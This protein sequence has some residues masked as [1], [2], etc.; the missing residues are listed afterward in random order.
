MRYENERPPVAVILAAGV[1]SRT[2]DIPAA[3]AKFGS[4]VVTVSRGQQ[5]AMDEAAA[6]PAPQTCDI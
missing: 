5:R 4:P 1:G 6:K 3:N 2:G